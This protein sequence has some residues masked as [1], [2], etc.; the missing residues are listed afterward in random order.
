MLT[1][2]SETTILVGCGRR[3]L[4]LLTIPFTSSMEI[5]VVEGIV[6]VTE[7][8]DKEGEEDEEKD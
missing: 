5:V 6:D 4:T 7:V 1:V 3:G 2:W 8:D